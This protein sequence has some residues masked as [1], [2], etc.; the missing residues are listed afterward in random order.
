MFNFHSYPWLIHR[1]TYGRPGQHLMH[2]RGYKEK[3]NIDTPLELAIR[4]E[5]DRFTLAILAIDHCTTLG[6]KGAAARERLKSE[7]LESKNYAY[8]E[9]ADPAEWADWKWPYARD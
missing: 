6:N 9:G 5:V 1:L 3:G 7:Q 4:N 2:V 8:T